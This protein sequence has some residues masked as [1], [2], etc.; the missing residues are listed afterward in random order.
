MPHSTLR[1][2]IAAFLL[3]ATFVASAASA[4]GLPWSLAGPPSPAG[5][6]ERAVCFLKGLW[7]KE[8]CGIDPDGLKGGCGIDPDGLKAGCGID[9][10]GLKEGCGIDPNGLKGG[11]GIDPSGSPLPSP[12]GQSALASQ[13]EA[14]CLIDPDGHCIR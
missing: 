10:D 12:T 4:A 8:G 3:A 14:G 7:E 9:P 2:P 1:R 5:F 13:G 11:C 6:L